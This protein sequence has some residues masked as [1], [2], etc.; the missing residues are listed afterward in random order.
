MNVYISADIE[1]ISGVVNRS[2]TSPEGYDYQRAR[3]LMTGEV[4]AAIRGAK[5]AGAKDILVNDSHGPM[6]NILIEELEAGARLL[7]GAHKTYGMMQGLDES[8][9][10]VLLIGYHGRHNTPGVL[11]H[12]YHGGVV[13]SIHLGELEVGEFEFNT[14]LAG[15]FGVPVVFVSGDQILAEQVRSFDSG[16]E[17]LAVKIAHNRYAADCLSPT[18]VHGLM[19]AGVQKAL[20]QDL[21]NL[22]INQLEGPVKLTVSFANSGM[23]EVCRGIPD[24]ILTN[25]HSVLYEAKSIK[26]A[27]TMRSVLTTLGASTI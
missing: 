18:T 6:T 16:I 27:Y 13:Q 15:A 11:A 23:A 4:N 25:P 5:A 21:K 3:R 26:E 14:L 19:E 7:T 1:G 8:F 22:K 10:A 9:D 12:S 17:A 24:I 2:H 20:E